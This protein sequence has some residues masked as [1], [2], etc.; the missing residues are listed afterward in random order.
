MMFVYK[1]EDHFDPVRNGLLGEC[2]TPAESKEM[3]DLISS[4]S[5]RIEWSQFHTYIRQNSRFDTVSEKLVISSIGMPEPIIAKVVDV[6]ARSGLSVL[7]YN[8]CEELCKDP[9]LTEKANSSMMEFLKGKPPSWSVFFH[10]EEGTKIPLTAPIVKPLIER[11][12]VN[13]IV[14]NLQA[15]A[16]R[17]DK[18]MK[19]VPIDHLPGTGG[20]TIAKHVLWKLRKEF[21]CVSMDGRSPNLHNFQDVAE[22]LLGFRGLQEDKAT[23]DGTSKTRTCKPVLLLMDNSTYEEAKLVQ[24]KFHDLVDERGIKFNKTMGMILLVQQTS[25]MPGGCNDEDKEDIHVN[26]KFSEKEKQL[27]KAKL[28]ELSIN[29][30]ISPENMIGFMI[31]S[32]ADS[33]ANININDITMRMLQTMRSYPAQIKLLLYLAIFKFY[34]DLNIAESHCKKLLGPFFTNE[35]ME[36]L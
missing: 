20:T 16:E 10:S 19:I 28:R 5:I 30:D 7:A 27:F 2:E 35:E 25:G 12:L 24:T 32:N 8:E 4:R 31:F 6:Y 22:K 21:R 9:E 13:K 15:N 33:E 14:R 17:A 34:G 3:L 36:F 18:C 26:T 11:D 1:D 23:I 29:E